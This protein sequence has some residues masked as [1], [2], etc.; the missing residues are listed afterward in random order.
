MVSR[1]DL[2]ANR[3]F[4]NAVLPLVRVIVDSKENIKKKFQGVNAIIQISAKNSNEKV[5]TH[6]LIEDGR[7]TVGKGITEN[8]TIELEFKS[9]P[10]F[11]AFFSGKSNR[12][13]KIRGWYNIKLLINT[14]KVLMTMASLLKSTKPPEDE[15]EK[16]LLVKLYFY[17]VSSGISQLNKAGH[18]DVS[19]WAKRSPERV[20]SWVIQDKPELSAYIKVKAGKTKAARGEYKRSKPFFTMHFDSVDSAL[21]ILLETDDMIDST[22]KGKLVME[23]APEYGAQI[24]EL[25][26]LVGS[27]AK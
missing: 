25:M 5:G 18:P 6:F 12:L 1:E 10:A 26:L 13:P 20:Y 24:G 16:D 22:K 17:L 14:L 15:K 23:G 7:W 2:F 19:K 11:N 21:G 4:L 3:I 8:P 27:Y 9:I